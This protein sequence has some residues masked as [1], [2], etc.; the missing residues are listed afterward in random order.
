MIRSRGSAIPIRTHLPA[1][2]PTGCGSSARADRHSLTLSSDI[3]RAVDYYFVGGRNMDEVIA[4]YRWLTGKAPIMP[5]WAYGF[6]QRRQRYETQDQLLAVLR[7]Y[8][9][10]ERPLD[11]SVQD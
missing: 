4:G 11:N 6:W 9:P 5:K 2:R 10:R 3:A 8:R 1:R 7:E